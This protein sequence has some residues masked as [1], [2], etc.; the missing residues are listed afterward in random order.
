MGRTVSAH[1]MKVH[2]Q[3]KCFG[4]T[5]VKEYGPLLEEIRAARSMDVTWPE[6]LDGCNFNEWV[7]TDRLARLG[8]TPI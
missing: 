7:C 5:C 3:G 4:N 6:N 8:N 2:S 1:N